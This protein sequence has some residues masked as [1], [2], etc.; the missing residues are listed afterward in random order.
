MHLV[1]I[2]TQCCINGLYTSP[3]ALQLQKMLYVAN[4]IA[5]QCILVTQSDIVEASVP[6]SL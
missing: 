3:W 4:R 5:I 2:Q 1:H 6:T